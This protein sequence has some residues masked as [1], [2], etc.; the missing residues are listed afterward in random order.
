MVVPLLHLMLKELTV[1][2][3]MAY[4][5]KDFKE[6]VEAFIAGKKCLTPSIE[7]TNA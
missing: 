3:S 1:K 4:D 2:A 6:T 7:K 5:D